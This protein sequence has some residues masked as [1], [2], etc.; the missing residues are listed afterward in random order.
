MRHNRTCERLLDIAFVCG[1]I[2]LLSGLGALFSKPSEL[3]IIAWAVFGTCVGMTVTL[4]WGAYVL[5]TPSENE[6]PPTT[7][8]IA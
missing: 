1:V 6:K 8:L 4:C 5:R 2:A 7:T 3:T